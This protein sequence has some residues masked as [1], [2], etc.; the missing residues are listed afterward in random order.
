MADGKKQFSIQSWPR[1]NIK[2]I[3]RV[4]AIDPAYSEK[5]SKTGYSVFDGMCISEHGTMTKAQVDDPDNIDR[6]LRD[7]D[8]LVVEDQ[9]FVVNAQVLMK[10]VYS[11]DL[12]IIPA[13]R[14]KTIRRIILMQPQ[15]WQSKVERKWS[16]KSKK[17]PDMWREYVKHRWGI[18]PA[19]IDT[20]ASICILSVHLDLSKIRY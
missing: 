9:H 4:L 13:K 3:P 16:F 18:S 14:Y 1:N 12:W 2:K 7:C 11:R 15:T 10:L 19:S 6:L 17:N 8:E 5:G 20:V